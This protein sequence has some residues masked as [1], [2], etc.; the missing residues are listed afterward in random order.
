MVTETADFLPQFI[1][2][3]PNFPPGADCRYCNCSYVLLGLLVEKISGMKYRDYVRQNIFAKAGMAHSD[4]Y[5]LERVNENVAEGADPLK[6]ERGQTLGWKRN[7]YSFPPVGSPDCGAY[8]T[9]GDLDI[10]LRAVKAGK[11][12]APEMTEA[13]FTPQV[14]YRPRLDGAVHYGYGLWFFIDQSGRVVFCEKEG[15][16]SGVSGLIRHYLRQDI[17]VVIL[18]NMAQGA[19]GPVEKIHKL[20]EASGMI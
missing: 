19:W 9:A 13:F 3:P 5:R 20:I 18:S 16:N 11:L 17:N 8:V 10:F 6:D 4:F 12:L 2:K 15:I 1:H 7:I 14:Y